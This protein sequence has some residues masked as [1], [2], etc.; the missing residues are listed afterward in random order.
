MHHQGALRHHLTLHFLLTSTKQIYV[1]VS[2]DRPHVGA[3]PFSL[4][5]MITYASIDYAT[6]LV[7]EWRLLHVQTNTSPPDGT[8]KKTEETTTTRTTKKGSPLKCV[9]VCGDD[10]PCNN[11][12]KMHFVERGNGSLEWCRWTTTAPPPHMHQQQQ[13]RT[14]KKRKRNKTQHTQKMIW[15]VCIKKSWSRSFALMLYR[16]KSTAIP[17]NQGSH[18]AWVFMNEKQKHNNN[19]GDYN[20][21]KIGEE[22][23]WCCKQISR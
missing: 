2:S 18:F 14:T 20:K 19:N 17:R 21:I 6:H 8:V 10:D 11:E 3:L 7:V 9:V 23:I 1:T 15:N 22:W 4:K 16:S 12:R 13:K 5:E